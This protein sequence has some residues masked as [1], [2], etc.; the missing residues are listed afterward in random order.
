M[1]DLY[2]NIRRRR[3][4]LGMSQQQLADKLGYKSRSAINKIEMGINDL[5]QSKIVAFAEALETTPGELMGWS[6]KKYKGAWRYAAPNYDENTVSFVF[7]PHGVKDDD[8]P[9]PDLNLKSHLVFAIDGTAGHHTATVS[10]EKSEKLAELLKAARDL[11]DDKIDMLIKMA[12]S[13]K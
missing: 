11:P 5:T 12:D 9:P 7:P 1:L 10:E 3:I 2:R 4:E 8:S 6:D 13:I